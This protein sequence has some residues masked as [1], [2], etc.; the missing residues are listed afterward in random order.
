MQLILNSVC[1]CMCRLRNR[2]WDASLLNVCR[3]YS[4]RLRYFKN[5]DFKKCIQAIKL[6]C[7]FFWLL[8]KKNVDE[9]FSVRLNSANNS[10]LMNYLHQVHVY[11]IG[12]YLFIIVSMIFPI[13]IAVS[14]DLSKR[15][16]CL[17]N[18]E[19]I[20][21][22]NLPFQKFKES[23]MNFMWKRIACKSIKDYRSCTHYLDNRLNWGDS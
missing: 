6:P 8:K 9:F 10:P 13:S 14:P 18:P 3:L 5:R 12:E 22:I 7:V 11:L 19:N 1:T 16:A 21:I 20:L 23:S 4:I 17:F 15:I 2:G